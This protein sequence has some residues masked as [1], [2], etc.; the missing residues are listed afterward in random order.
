MGPIWHHFQQWAWRQPD[1]D[2]ND[3]DGHVDDDDD[4][5]EEDDDDDDDDDETATTTTID[6]R[7]K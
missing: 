2:V 1:D 6:E 4:N 7:P 5:N 3:H